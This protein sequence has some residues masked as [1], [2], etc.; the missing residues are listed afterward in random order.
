M[1]LSISANPATIKA[2]WNVLGQRKGRTMKTYGFVALG[3]AIAFTGN[4]DAGHWVRAPFV[5]VYVGRDWGN[6]SSVYVR[7]PFVRVGVPSWDGP[8]YYYPPYVATPMP[9]YEVRPEDRVP[10]PAPRPGIGPTNGTATLQVA[11]R[12]PTHREFAGSFLPRPGTYEVT[13][14]HPATGEPCVVC[15]TLPN[16]GRC[17]VKVDDDEIEFDYDGCE[18]EIHFKRDG[19]VVVDYDD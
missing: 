7:A 17:K 19:R 18:V 15:F 6:G 13:L 9:R 3:L 8:V 10:P 14:L 5:S 4:A 1:L 11:D 12:P 2:A 16:A